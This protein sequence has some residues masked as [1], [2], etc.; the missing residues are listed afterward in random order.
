MVSDELDYNLLSSYLNSKGALVKATR[1]RGGITFDVSMLEINDGKRE[2][3]KLIL[4]KSTGI[5]NAKYSKKLQKEYKLL[6]LLE[7]VNIPAP[8]PLFFSKEKEIHTHPFIV[9]KYIDGE[10]QFELQNVTD[11]IKKYTTNLLNIHNINIKENDSS[12]LPD[13]NAVLSNII[14][15]IHNDQIKDQ[16]FNPLKTESYKNKPVLVHGDYWPG[17]ILWYKN[18]IV[19][20]IDWE[21]AFIGDPLLDVANSRLELLWAFD[22]S[23]MNEFTTIYKQKQ[24][25][26]DFSDLWL[27]DLFVSRRN[28]LSLDKWPIDD[29]KKDKM[30]KILLWFENQALK[31]I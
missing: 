11:Y 26:L 20:T 7:R 30:K 16:V 21:D 10:T 15:E 3:E 1:L 2:N 19:A 9:L 31:Q 29:L 23:A 22:S 5:D 24:Q 18:E 12:F 14:N 17:N 4:R 28:S 27:W 13:Q 25:Q 8:I 6:Q